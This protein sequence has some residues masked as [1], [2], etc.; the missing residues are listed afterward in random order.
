MVRPTTAT[1]FLILFCLLSDGWAQPQRASGSL[2]SGL[3]IART[4]SRGQSQRFSLELVQGQLAQIVV[5]QRGIDVIVRVF[6][7]GW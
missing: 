4:I 7:P 5:D 3:P 6:S 2:Q 1:S